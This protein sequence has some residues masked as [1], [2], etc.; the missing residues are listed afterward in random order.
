[1]HSSSCALHRSC[2]LPRR[3]SEHRLTTLETA[4]NPL[5]PHPGRICPVRRAI[6]VP[7]PTPGATNHAFH[8]PKPALFRFGTYDCTLNTRYCGLLLT[9]TIDSVIFSSAA[10]EWTVNHPDANLANLAAAT[11][12]RCIR[13]DPDS[14]RCRVKFRFNR[15]R[16]PGTNGKASYLLR[17]GDPQ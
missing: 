7:K 12:N 15:P 10:C 4:R 6:C 16:L 8:R 1:M 2:A 14:A 13:F 11:C 5:H 3:H 9:R 17:R